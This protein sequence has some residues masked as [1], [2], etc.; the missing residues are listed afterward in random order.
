MGYAI[1]RAREGLDGCVQL[2]REEYTA[3]LE[4]YTLLSEMLMLEERFDILLDNYC[5]LEQEIL[6]ISLQHSIRFR[7]SD[8]SMP[9]HRRI[10]SR[11]IL[12][13][14]SA[15]RFYLDQLWHGLSGMFGES[16]DIYRSIKLRCSEHYDSSFEYRL[17]EAVRNSFQH[18]SMPI[19]MLTVNHQRTEIG[20]SGRL[21]CTATPRLSRDALLADGKLKQTVRT[22]LISGPDQLDIKPPIRAY[23]E[24]LADLHVFVRSEASEVAEAWDRSLEGIFARYA[25]THDLPAEERPMQLEL[26]ELQDTPPVC[27]RVRKPITPGISEMRKALEQR[28]SLLTNLGKRYVTNQPAEDIPCP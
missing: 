19:R 9:E 20:P 28:N 16:S 22:E 10:L 11:R 7:T 8:D 18:R 24:A 26:V 17:M 5:E 27:I 14:L 13:L 15:C 3:V 21:A 2:A 25:E 4:D 6:I 23:V 1:F 12:N